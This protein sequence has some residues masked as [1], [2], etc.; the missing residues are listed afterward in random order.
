MLRVL[1]WMLTV[2]VWINTI[3]TSAAYGKDKVQLPLSVGLVLT[4]IMCLT[5]ERI[6]AW[7]K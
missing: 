2:L 3:I 4:A 6:P 7:F 1:F 5:S